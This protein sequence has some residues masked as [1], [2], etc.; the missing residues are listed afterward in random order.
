MRDMCLDKCSAL[1]EFGP[2]L[3][4][5]FDLKIPWLGKQVGHASIEVHRRIKG[6]CH[7]AEGQGTS[8][9]EISRKAGI[10]QATFCNWSV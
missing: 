7:P 3:V 8:V 5:V 9:A 4:K 6:D 1:S 2:F 10:S